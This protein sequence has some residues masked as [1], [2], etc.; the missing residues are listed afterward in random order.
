MLTATIHPF[1]A[2]LGH[3][4]VVQQPPSQPNN[5]RLNQQ[6]LRQIP[7]GTR[8]HRPPAEYGGSE[9]YNGFTPAVLDKVSALAAQFVAHAHIDQA[10]SAQAA[11]IHKMLVN[12]LSR[13][14]RSCATTKAATTAADS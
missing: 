7:T 2:Q 14:S 12:A 4:T 10:V 6:E 1:T 8:W 3:R 5:R 13:S 9:P 11:A